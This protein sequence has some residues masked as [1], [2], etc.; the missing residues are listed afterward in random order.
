MPRTDECG[1]RSHRVGIKVGQHIVM[2]N[3]NLQL[4]E[5]RNK[6]KIL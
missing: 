1:E 2:Q 5:I 3:Q 6:V 4:F